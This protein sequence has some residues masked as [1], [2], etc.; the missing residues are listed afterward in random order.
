[1]NLVLG[2]VLGNIKIDRA[3]IDIHYDSYLN[4][5]RIG[6][7]VLLMSY[8]MANQE[9]VQPAK[10]TFNCTHSYDIC[11][12]PT[13]GIG[14]TQTFTACTLEVYNC[15]NRN[16]SKYMRYYFRLE[17]PKLLQKIYIST[18][19]GLLYNGTCD[20]STFIRAG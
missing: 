11:C 10:C 15:N 17:S 9:V 19:Y 7:T 6:G 5:L 12:G 14:R 16:N 1:M 20:E 13:S 3:N 8:V 18:A 2:Y 4:S